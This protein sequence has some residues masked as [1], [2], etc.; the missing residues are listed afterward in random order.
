VATY[1]QSATWGM[2]SMAT[3]GL[4]V[5]IFSTKRIWDSLFGTTCNIGNSG[6]FKL[7]F[8]DY[9]TDGVVDPTESFADFTAYG[10]FGGWTQPYLKQ[11]GGTVPI[12]NLCNNP[13]WHALIDI[14]WR[15]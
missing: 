6:V 5:G 4:S 15:Q 10:G 3:L 1:C 8:A 11:V 14:N 12:T 2:S 7:W 9:Q 13:A